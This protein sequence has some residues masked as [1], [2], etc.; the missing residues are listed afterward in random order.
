MAA[1][2]YAKVHI[3]KRKRRKLSKDLS[4]IIREAKRARNLKNEEYLDLHD[5][6]V[7]DEMNENARPDDTQPTEPPLIDVQPAGTSL[8]QDE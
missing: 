2:Y 6:R 7:L 8:D 4:T 5:T 1:L 3:L